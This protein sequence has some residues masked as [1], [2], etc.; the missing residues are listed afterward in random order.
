M[1]P[2]K[3][4]I[5][6][7]LRLKLTESISQAL[8]T[9]S[10]PKKDYSLAPPK[11]SEFG[12]LSS[13]IALLLSRDLNKQPIDIAKIIADELNRAL[14]ENITKVTIAKPGFLNFEIS[15]EFFQSQIIK[16]L[17][18]N[19]S[20]GKGDIGSG[21]TANVEF[22]S[23]NPTGPLTV[24]HGRN[25]ILGDT[26]SN[27]LQWQGFEVTREYYFNDAG[28]QMRILGKSVEVRYF[29]ILGKNLEFPEEGYQGSYIKDIAQT[30]LNQYGNELKSDDPIFNKEAEKIIFHDIKS[31]LIKLGI[32]FDK[33]TNEKTFYENGDIDSFLEELK[34]KNLI[35]EKDNA[36]W[37]KTSTL[38]KD[39]DR[40][41]IKSSGEPT[42]RVPDTAY[43]Q[44]KVKRGFDLIID[45]FGAD[46]TDA[47]PDVILALEALGH[48]TDHIKV[49]IYQFV[50]LLR[51]G[52]KIKMSTRK[53]NFV[54]L[55][56]LVDEVGI[57]VVRYF[58]VMRSMNAHLDFDLDLAADQSDKNPVFYLQYAH[59]RICNIISRANDMGVG[60]NDSFDPSLLEHEDEIALLK[61]MSRFPDFLELAYENLEP[62]TIANYLQELSAR[63][64]KFYSHCRVITDDEQLTISRI[65]VIHASKIILANGFKIL[66]ISAPERM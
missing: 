27:I 23:A 58:F 22:V 55:D 65:A 8:R 44:D 36:T 51:G 1:H 60:L 3:K 59:A 48:K 19:D 39:Q 6:K 53:A 46:H 28:R 24:G 54:T 47:Y 11:N 5:M 16:I 7:D 17:E 12:D 13:N 61:Y 37:F 50:T 62:Q 15:N 26:V 42:Y 40:V 33:F 49:L 41:Y 32:T 18:D 52:E 34:E 21:K 57:D 31:S 4:L 56:E 20:Y 66:G 29:E 43:H 35:Y 45:V 64:H 2:L 9:L 25:A 14:P 38:G 30:I 10:F 63:F